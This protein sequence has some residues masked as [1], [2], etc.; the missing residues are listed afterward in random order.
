MSI[1]YDIIL[2]AVFI[3][4]VWRGWRRGALATL[5]WLAGWVVALFIIGG[6]GATWAEN[7]YNDTVEPWAVNAVE[8]AIPAGTVEAMNSGADAVESIQNILDD[9][10]GMLGGRTV[11]VTDAEAIKSALRQDSTSLAENITQSVLRP[12]LKPVVKDIV[13]VVILI[14]VLFVFRLLSR[15]AARRQGSH[16]VLSKTNH[17]LGGVLGVLEAMAAAYVLALLLEILASVLNVSWLTPTIL[18]ET[19]II[20]RLI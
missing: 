4:V 11:T 15:M 1:V 3:L 18:R 7:L 13:Y 20:R 17:L 2:A 10:S 12:V 16:G 6:W 19:V 8:K 9:L 14:V 5:L